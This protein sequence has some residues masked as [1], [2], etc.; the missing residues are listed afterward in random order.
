MCTDDD[1]KVQ[2]IDPDSS[3]QGQ[4][5]LYYAD[6]MCYAVM[7]RSIDRSTGWKKQRD[8]KLKVDTSVLLDLK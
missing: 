7:Y 1:N 2:Q 5:T 8:E 4:P 6:V 3:V